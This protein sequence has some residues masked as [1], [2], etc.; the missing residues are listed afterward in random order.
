MDNRRTHRGE[1]PVDYDSKMAMACA[2][3]DDILA[4]ESYGRLRVIKRT[5]PYYGP[6]LEL[7]PA[8][9]DAESRRNEDSG[10]GGTDTRYCL[11]TG[12]MD[13]GLELWRRTYDA[14]DNAM[15]VCID[16]AATAELDE[17]PS[18]PTCFCGA[19]L[20]TKFERSMY[21]LSD[22]CPH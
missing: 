11:T 17:V 16:E 21:F 20:E 8:E 19:P 10:D 15:W 12:G 22:E 5:D 9:N 4:V 18:K 13:S 2:S 1:S 6:K 7:V 3:L 14:D